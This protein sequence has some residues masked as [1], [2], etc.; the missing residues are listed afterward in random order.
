M[1]DATKSDADAEAE[2]KS[3]AIERAKAA[4]AKFDGRWS[5]ERIE[6]AAVAA[7]EVA[8][9]AS[10]DAARGPAAPVKAKEPEPEDPKVRAEVMK[11]AHAIGMD[12]EDLKGRPLQE[13]LS[14]VGKFS[15][16]TALARSSERS[17]IFAEAAKIGINTE[18]PEFQKLSNAEILERIGTVI[19][20]RAGRLSVKAAPD[21]GKVSVRV[22]RAGEGKISKGVHVP[23][24]GDLTYKQGDTL[25]LLRR[26]AA[27]LEARGFVEITG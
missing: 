3:Y 12:L 13:V 20:A 7:E 17:E 6:A 19:T 18:D 24:V 23:G 8:R 2:L 21:P 4:G 25:E 15:T 10:E 1:T 9:K 5:A 14:M 11:E 27:E 16:E 22:L 26:S